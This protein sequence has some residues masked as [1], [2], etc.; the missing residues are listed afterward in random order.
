MSLYY[1]QTL[2]LFVGFYLHALQ[3]GENANSV[4]KTTTAK[5]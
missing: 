3:N 1:T 2:K 4:D 5:K